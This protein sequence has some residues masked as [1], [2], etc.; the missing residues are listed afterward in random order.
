MASSD[1][2][3][4]DHNNA[5]LRKFKG[6]GWE[7]TYSQKSQKQV[8]TLLGESSDE[9]QP[10]E[11]L[12]SEVTRPDLFP[13]IRYQRDWADTVLNRT[14]F[15]TPD[16]EGT[17]PL[18]L[19]KVT[20]DSDFALF[21]LPAPDGRWVVK[22]TG[23]IL[24]PF[25]NSLDG[26]AEL[27]ELMEHG[28]LLHHAVS[29]ADDL[30][31]LKSA[32]LIRPLYT[33]DNK[34]AGDA[35]H[36]SVT[37]ARLNAGTKADGKEDRWKSCADDA[38]K[39]LR[40]RLDRVL[41]EIKKQDVRAASAIKKAIHFKDGQFL[42]SDSAKWKTTINDIP[43]DASMILSGKKWEVTFPDCDESLFVADGVAMR[44]IA[45]LLMCNSSACPSALLSD[46]ELLTE[47]LSRP[48]HHKYFE[49]THRN[50]KVRC[51][52]GNKNEVEQAVCAALRFKEG[53]SYAADHVISEKSEL[54]TVCGL[55]ISQV[56]LRNADALEGILNLL[57]QKQTKLFFVRPPSLEFKQILSDIEVGVTFARKQ[58]KL[59]QQIH[60]KSVDLTPNIQKAIFRLQNELREKSDW[61]NH[62]DMLADHLA[63]YVRGGIV[64]QYTGPYRWRIKG[65]SPTPNAVEMAYDHTAYKRR[66]LYKAKR[67]AELRLAAIRILSP[68]SAR[69]AMAGL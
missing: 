31:L 9:Q 57:K 40:D 21:Q 27:H 47:F 64:F 5:R 52:N 43:Y 30:T 38:S 15:W 61:T 34:S 42:F 10:K 25:K 33:R 44:A 2:G 59:L 45:R 65:I 63:E 54:H 1:F 18:W 50:Q 17:A 14:Y 49:A 24:E 60:P 68:V 8:S 66:K 29:T 7:L 37:G 4:T 22:C 55:P 6:D 51:G 12:K 67:K 62:Y 58:E 3:M 26:W 13:E 48:R 69:G 11:A 36:C 28:Y 56:T 41:T 16:D 53:W 46:G 32:E 23:K 35:I 19:E 20:E 39:Q